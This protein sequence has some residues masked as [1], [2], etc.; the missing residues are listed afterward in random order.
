[1]FRSAIRLKNRS[2]MRQIGC[3]RPATSKSRK[4][5]TNFDKYR[6]RSFNSH[7]YC[8]GDYGN[9]VFRYLID[10]QCVWD[11]IILEGP[12]EK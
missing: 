10:F 6:N 8:S 9:F 7:Q 2:K 4:A 11:L 3:C 12:S 5:L 1:R